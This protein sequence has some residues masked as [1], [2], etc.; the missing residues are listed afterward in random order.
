M[1]KERITKL[2]DRYE[3]GEENLTAGDVLAEIEQIVDEEP[4]QNTDMEIYL[5]DAIRQFVWMRHEAARYG[6]RCDDGS[7]TFISDV[8]RIVGYEN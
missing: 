7:D 6:G 8:K 3:D 1:I 4:C 5:Q 2:I